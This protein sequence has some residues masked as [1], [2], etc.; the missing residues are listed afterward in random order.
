M[1]RGLIPT[2]ACVLLLAAAVVAES[3]YRSSPKTSADAQ[4]SGKEV[5]ACKLLTSAEIESVQGARVEE[6]RPSRQ[7]SGG[8]VFSQCLFRTSAPALSVSVSLAAPASQ[9]PRDFWRKQFHAGKEKEE[10]ESHPGAG[11]KKGARE[12]E[13]G[14]APKNIKGVGD[15]AYWVGGPISGALYVLRANTFIRISVGGV[16]EEPARM[17]KSVALARA[18]L[19]RL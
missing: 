12:E 4:S 13:E 18:A 5:D 16:R 6:T 3:P 9:Q 14:S 15:E 10:H 8:L 17:Q 11:G 2:L 19:K 7:P 1:N